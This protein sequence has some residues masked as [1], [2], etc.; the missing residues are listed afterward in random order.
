MNGDI[1]NTAVITV[2]GTYGTVWSTVIHPRAKEKKKSDAEEAQRQLERDRDLDGI[3]AIEG[4]TEGTPRLV[5]RVARVEGQ[6]V[7]VVAGQGLLEQRM[8]E[9]NGTGKKT[10]DMVKELYDDF[11]KRTASVA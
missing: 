11:K 4:M 2:A 7:K 1:L 10:N 6:M 8:N 9:A 5:V 3:P